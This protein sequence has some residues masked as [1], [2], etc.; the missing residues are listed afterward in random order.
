MAGV[1]KKV[2]Q[3]TI[4]P[5]KDIIEAKAPK[6]REKM[7]RAMEAAGKAVV[8]DFTNVKNIDSVGLAVIIAS[9]NTLKDSG[10]G[11]KLKNLSQEQ[12]KLFNALG[13]G[14][15]IELKPIG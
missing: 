11:L 4:K 12:L 2:N 1:K 13:V 3:K 9:H 14:E 7:L 8:L 15:Y 5:G 10:M 6:L